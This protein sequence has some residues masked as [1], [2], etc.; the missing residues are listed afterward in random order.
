MRDELNTNVESDEYYA[1]EHLEK[2]DE[3]QKHGSICH[4]STESM[5]STFDEFQFMMNQTNFDVIALSETWLKNDKH[6]L[7]YVR[8]PGFEFAYRIRDEKGGGGVGIY[9]RDK[10]EFKE[11]RN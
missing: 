3:L 10:I 1:N 9:I 4:L 8:L 7:E 11:I 5:S 6:V 2:L